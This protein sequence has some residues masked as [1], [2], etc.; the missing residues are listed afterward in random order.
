MRICNWN[1]RSLHRP[2]AVNQLEKLLRKYETDITALQEMRRTAQGRTNLSTCDVYY[3]GHASRHVFGCGFAVSK[4]F[5]KLVSGLAVDER[6]A[7]SRIKA[8]YFYISLICAP[9]VPTKDKDDTTKDAF[10]DKLEVA[11][12]PI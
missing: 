1:V 8:K 7:A 11:Q 4:K 10:Y 9:Y 6:L 2:A 3:S 5:R 12:D